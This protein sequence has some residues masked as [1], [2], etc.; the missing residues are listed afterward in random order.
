MKLTMP[1]LLVE[2]PWEG[3]NREIPIPVEVNLAVVE[4]TMPG[5]SQ[6][7]ISFNPD[8]SEVWAHSFSHDDEVGE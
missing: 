1:D 7:Q 5:F 8:L 2:C 3:C 6:Q 4:S